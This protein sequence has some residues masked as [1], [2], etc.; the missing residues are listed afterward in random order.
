LLT[1]TGMMIAYDLSYESRTLSTNDMWT[2]S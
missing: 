1:F 2:S